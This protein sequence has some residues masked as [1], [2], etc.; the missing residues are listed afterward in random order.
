MSEALSDQ[1]FDALGTQLRPGGRIAYWNLL[2]PRRSP[3][4]LGHKLTH[5][6]ALSESLF[7]RDRSWFCRAFHVEGGHPMIELLI[8]RR[9]ELLVVLALITLGLSVGLPTAAVPDNS[10]RIWF[11]DDDPELLAYDAF[12][13]RF[14]NDE[15]M[16]LNVHAPEGVFEPTL[17]KRLRS[18]T[19]LEAQEGSS[20]CTR[21]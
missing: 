15:V 4:A 1:V 3:A 11:L 7:G 10:L 21:S 8:Q 6:S 17:L 18:L 5:L 12:H 16:L 9:R 13:E 19:A 20:G 14:G 2:V